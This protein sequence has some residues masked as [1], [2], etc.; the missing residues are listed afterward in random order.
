MPTF[1][2]RVQRWLPIVQA[3]LARVGSPLPAELVLA[4]IDTESRGYAGAT[5]PS[6]GASGLM[7]VMPGT[8]EG[9]NQKNTPVSLAEL[10]SKTD[11]AAVKQIRV[12]LWV[13][14]TYWR[15]AWRYLS[16]RLATVPI[17][18]LARVADLFYVAGPGATRKRLDK[19]PSPTWAAI[20]AAFPKWNALPH[21]KRV[22]GLL[23]DLQWPVNQI[24]QWLESKQSII[25]DPTPKEGLVMAAAAILLAWWFLKKKGGQDG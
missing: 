8:L 15:S 7:Q 19:L 24:S 9:Y 3:E 20:Q 18:E 14:N 23:S 22:F 1:R 5:N 11:A 6:S 25:L 12:G 2:K 17:D 10:R 4:V 21:P 16:N 13:M